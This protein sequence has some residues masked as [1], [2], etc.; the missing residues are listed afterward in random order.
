M[1]NT[2]LSS[3]QDN[4]WYFGLI[5]LEYYSDQKVYYQYDMSLNGEAVL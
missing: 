3:S 1:Y 5:P 2:S 4:Y